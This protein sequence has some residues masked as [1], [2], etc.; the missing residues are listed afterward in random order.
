MRTIYAYSTKT[1]DD[2]PDEEIGKYLKVGDTSR[3]ADERIDEQ[4]G[5]SQYEPLLKKLELQVPD[6]IRD[7]NIHTWLER[8]G[9]HK[10]RSDKRREWFSIDGASLEQRLEVIRRACRELTA[11]P[12]LGKI[13]FGVHPEQHRAIEELLSSYRAGEHT[14]L[15]GACPRFGKTTTMLALFS[16]PDVRARVLVVSAFWQSSLHSFEDDAH[17]FLDF[18][19]LVVLDAKSDPEFGSKL[20]AA[21]HAGKKVVA[22]V[23]LVKS[24]ENDG[25]LERYRKFHELAD[26]DKIVFTDEADFGAH[27]TNAQE[28][29]R[30]IRGNAFLVVATGTNIDRAGKPYELDRVHEVTYFELLLSRTPEYQATF[31]KRE[32]LP[33]KLDDNLGQRLPSVEFYQLRY[34]VIDCGKE[35]LDERDLPSWTKVCQRPSKATG[36]IHS[37]FKTLW[38]GENRRVPHLAL[39]N[40]FKG[41]APR[42]TMVWLGEATR[43][44]S[45]KEFAV[46]LRSA[47]PTV[48]VIELHGEIT[49][50]QESELLVEG[51]LNEMG[52]EPQYTDGFIILSCKMG[53]RSFSIPQ[54]DTVILAY[55]E[56]SA[57]QTAQK[58]SRCLTPE[59]GNSHKVGRVVSISF[60]PTRTDL[61]DYPIAETA[62]RY[63]DRTGLDFPTAARALL[64]S[65]PFFTVDS[66]GDTSAIDPDDYLGRILELRNLSKLIAVKTNYDAILGDPDQLEG[67]LEFNREGRPRA[68]EAP[69]GGQKGKGFREKR[70]YQKGEPKPDEQKER[71]SLLKEMADRILIITDNVGV[72][73]GLGGE[74]TLRA[75]VGNIIAD[76]ELEESFRHTFGGHPKLLLQLLDRKQID[77]K[78][79]DAGLDQDWHRNQKRAEEF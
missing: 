6:H 8:H 11:D 44:E 32:E 28:V 49:T 35:L 61:L 14:F 7:Y 34:P 15:L 18:G 52:R 64:K 73:A 41:Y 21:L 65:I 38:Y 23:S 26:D 70:G 56:G 30:Y 46:V 62:G 42:G 10:V 40:V 79:I 48:K 19:D 60:S 59:H 13:P 58:M 78:L 9:H 72:I 53:A 54:I 77:E 31:K 66:E 36:F 68:G 57:A 24:R 76:Q 33:W 22:L 20:A 29:V 63:A 75:S 74:R 47:L 27:R 43:R 50:G 39:R 71:E 16:H 69:E 51:V 5:T 45:L 55:D 12:K 37:M 17:K 4:D 3:T 67:L 25:Y 1:I 2:H